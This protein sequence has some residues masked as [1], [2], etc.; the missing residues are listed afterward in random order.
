MTAALKSKS[1]NKTKKSK[2]KAKT[3]LSDAKTFFRKILHSSES[4]DSE[5]CKEVSEDGEFL[6]NSSFSE[7]ENTHR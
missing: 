4:E 2:K 5:A 6:N 1:K 7:D 3:N